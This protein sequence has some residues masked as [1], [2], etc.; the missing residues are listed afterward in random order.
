MPGITCAGQLTGKGG[1]FGADISLERFSRSLKKQKFRN[2]SVPFL[3]DPEGRVIVHSGEN[4]PKPV[5]ADADMGK[6]GTDRS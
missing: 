1:V 3:F 5:V 4:N 6:A 2:R